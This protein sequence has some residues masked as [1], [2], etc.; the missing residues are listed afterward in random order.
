ME[1]N[2]KNKLNFCTHKSIKKNNRRIACQIETFNSQK[3][4]KDKGRNIFCI[5]DAQGASIFFGMIFKDNEN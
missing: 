2:Y 1:P 4:G 3:V 5:F